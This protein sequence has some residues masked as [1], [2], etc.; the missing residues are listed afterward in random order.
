MAQEPLVTPEY[1]AAST[2]AD[3]TT[4]PARVDFLILEASAMVCEWLGR[5]YAAADAPVAVKQAV[6]I[7]VANVLGDTD[8]SSPDVKSEAIGDYKVEFETGTSST[9]LDIRQVEYLL[10]GLKG[11][12]RSVKT[13]VPLDGV[14][15]ES[16]GLVVN[17]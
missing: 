3:V 1:V 10:T 5:T 13:N 8:P 6:S 17:R 7:M 15:V 4:D 12:A 9:G 16:L 11:N 2:G 14:P